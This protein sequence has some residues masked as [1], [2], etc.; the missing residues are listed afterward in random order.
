MRLRFSNPF[1]GYY[2][3]NVCTQDVLATARVD[4]SAKASCSHYT[5]YSGTDCSQVYQQFPTNHLGGTNANNQTCNSMNSGGSLKAYTFVCSDSHGN[6]NNQQQPAVTLNGYISY[7]LYSDRA[8]TK[9]LK[10]T[11][12]KPSQVCLMS[13]E[14]IQVPGSNNLYGISKCSSTLPSV[15]QGQMVIH[16]YASLNCNTS[17]LQHSQY[18][19]IQTCSVN[20]M[21]S[22][23][24][25]PHASCS[26]YQSYSDMECQVAANKLDYTSASCLPNGNSNSLSVSCQVIPVVLPSNSTKRTVSG[27][28]SIQRENISTVSYLR[29]TQDCTP[30]PSCSQISDI[31]FG[32][33]GKVSCPS[34]V[35]TPRPH[36][37]QVVQYLNGTQCR[38]VNV[39][40][41]YYPKDVCTG[42]LS[43]KFSPDYSV[44][45]TCDQL[46]SYKGTNCNSTEIY[47][48]ISY[49]NSTK[50]SMDSE[51]GLGYS[52]MCS[53]G[54]EPPQPVPSP[55]QPPAKSN[56]TK[57]GN[58]ISLATSTPKANMFLLVVI[59]MVCMGC[60]LLLQL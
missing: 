45:A 7:D 26:S 52:L 25:M 24:I 6:N 36:Q 4:Y 31:S 58:S 3:L 27:A 37:V 60:S 11:I 39:H 55:I 50:C 5:A 56:S 33:Y 47:K 48:E 17:T 28:I 30:N 19:P 21:G 13:G 29:A 15:Q 23:S 18:Y 9:K 14:C 38:F 35:P 59:V 53:N 34:A 54:T 1:V 40:I 49:S 12:V 43:V 44:K 10:S 20:M 42:D 8:C 22:G 46:I 16:T 2:P 41:S 57:K 51:Y 32:Y